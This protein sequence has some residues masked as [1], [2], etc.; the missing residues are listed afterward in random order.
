[1]LPMTVSGHKV[2]EIKF[3]VLLAAYVVIH[4]SKSQS[5]AYVV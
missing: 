2:L 4:A 1:M 3:K 5:I